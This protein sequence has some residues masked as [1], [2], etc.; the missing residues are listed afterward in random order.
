[1][2]HSYGVD[3]AGRDWTCSLSFSQNSKVYLDH[4]WWNLP[5]CLLETCQL[6]TLSRR[7]Y[8]LISRFYTTNTHKQTH[9]TCTSL[10]FKL[11]KLIKNKRFNNWNIIYF[12]TF[13]VTSV[14]VSSRDFFIL[15]DVSESVIN[16]KIA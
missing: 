1:M 8:Y 12:L 6:V 7:I 14:N 5:H 2:V 10:S 13:F 15:F 11:Y 9:K 16:N 4:I 3:T